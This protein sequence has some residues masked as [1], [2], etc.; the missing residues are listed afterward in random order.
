M[1]EKLSFDLVSPERLLLSEEVDMV[2]LPGAEGDMGIMGGHAPV[3]S[4]LRPGVIDVDVQGQ[5]QRRY[6]V[7]GGF[8]EVT[9]AGLTILAEHTVP[10]A[11]LDT[12]ALDREIGNAEEDVADAKTD[13]KRQAA[14]EKLDHLKQLRQAI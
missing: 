6:F 4:T 14:Q 11:E 12:A 2:V 1:A 10:L 8:A 13:A 3:M 5:P 9:P 7:R